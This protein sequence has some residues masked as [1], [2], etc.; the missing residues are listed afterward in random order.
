MRKNLKTVRSLLLVFIGVCL[1]VNGTVFVQ[2]CKN[3]SFVES[4]ATP[5]KCKIERPKDKEIVSMEVR[6]KGLNAD[7]YYDKNAKCQKAIIV[8]GGSEGGK[9]WSKDDAKKNR[10]RFLS[11]GYA[12]LSL[13]YFAVEG[14]PNTLQCIPMEYFNTAIDWVLKQPGIDKKGVAVIGLSK[15]GEASLLLASLNPKVKAVVALVPA[16]NVFQG[17]GEDVRSSWSYKGEDVPFA[18]F[19]MNDA[20]FEGYRKMNEEG[21]LEFKQVYKDAIANPE[22]DEM[23]AIKVEKSKADILLISGK[24][25]VLWDS[26]GMCQKIMKRLNDKKYKRFYEHISYETGH[27]LY[28]NEEELFSDILSF[29]KS[30]YGCQN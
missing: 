15:G 11:K 14:L 12:V 20:Y 1:L 22:I 13:G 16:S 30:H 3:G 24:N 21:I 6:E 9:S 28:E 25:D 18:P 17:L 10:M 29:L 2:A 19:V 4:K 5:K 26:E 23:S 27:N 7:F 8:F